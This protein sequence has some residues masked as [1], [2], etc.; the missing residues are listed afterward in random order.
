MAKESII[1]V[2][3][4][5]GNDVFKQDGVWRIVNCIEYVMPLDT[6]KQRIVGVS[7][8]DIFDLYHKDCYDE[9]F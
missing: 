4:K 5:C 8:N 2:C 9:W 7:E 6:G 1:D 3:H